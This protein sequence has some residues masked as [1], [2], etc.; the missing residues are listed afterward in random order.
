MRMKRLTGYL[1]LVLLTVGCEEIQGLP[2]DLTNLGFRECQEYFE[3][4]F[5]SYCTEQGTCWADC[6][7]STDCDPIGTNMICNRFGQCLEREEVRS[8][9]RHE[10]CGQGRYCNG[11]CSL[12]EAVC[13]SPEE[14]PWPAGEE[15]QGTCGAHCGNENDCPQGLECTPVGQCLLKGWERWIPPGEV[16]PSDCRIDALCKTLGWKWYCDCE[17]E[18]DPYWGMACA[19]GGT[20][21]CVEDPNPIDFGSGPADHPAHEMTGSRCPTSRLAPSSWKAGNA[22]SS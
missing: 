20:S 5:G 16:P 22:I 11:H 19:G 3:C 9:S 8:C 18:L 4:G 10:D 14:C 2:A 7:T 13:G 17:M 15:C 12:S 1:F 21:V 6:R